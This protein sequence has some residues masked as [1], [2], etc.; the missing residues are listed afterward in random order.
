MVNGD[1]SP[2][3]TCTTYNVTIIFTDRLWWR[4]TLVRRRAICAM[5]TTLTV[6]GD[7][8]PVYT[9]YNVT[10]TFTDRLWWRVTLVRRRAICA[11]WT[12]PMV[13]GGVSPVY[14]TSTKTGMLR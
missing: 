5:W 6:M 12:T 11:M 14:T 4:D 7:V 1:V 2:V 9:T 8:S 10:I 3:Y 13:M